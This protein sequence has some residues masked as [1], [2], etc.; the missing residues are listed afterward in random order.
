MSQQKIRLMN[1]KNQWMN[2]N[3]RRMVLVILLI[4]KYKLL[5]QKILLEKLLL[6]L[7]ILGYF[8]FCYA[9]DSSS[10]TII[11]LD[12]KTFRRVINEQFSNLITGQTK[13]S[14][15]NFASLDLKESE[16]SF[17]G[18]T[19]TKAG[20]VFGLVASG[21]VSDGLFSIFNN[22]TLN[23]KISLEAQMNFLNLSK[24]SL[25]W[26]DD[27]YQEYMK[28]Q[29]EIK[30]KHRVKL[31]EAENRFALINLN[32]KKAKLEKTLQQLNE[33][34]ATERSQLTSDS[35]NY[36]IALNQSELTETNKAITSF[37]DKVSA[38]E[39][40]NNWRAMEL[41]KIKPEL[42]L[43]GFNF[44]WWSLSYK[45]INNSFKLFDPSKE[46]QKQ[47]WDSSFVTHQVKLQYSYYNWT[48]ESN[49][50]Y[51]YCIGISFGVLDN[52]SD[53]TKRE[54]TEV[55]NYGANINDRSTTK[56]YNAYQGGYL[57]KL[58]QIKLF[59]DYYHFL[60]EGNTAAFHL[61]PEFQFKEGI[62]PLYNFGIGLLLAFK[63]SKKDDKS[64]VNAEIFYNF[65]DL[66]NNEDNN[67]GFLERN[68]IGLRFSFPINFVNK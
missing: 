40:V 41:K 16:V 49:K 4:S 20:H 59:G 27:S 1:Q 34:L 12:K 15:G 24:Q 25:T 14:I 23:T 8:N 9:Q 42:E 35:L 13:T 64:V 50:T 56:K 10:S 30:D 37:P 29:A 67:L 28:K 46:Y 44:G 58:S 61:Y 66:S 55:K 31:V 11:G 53:L 5:R 33:R 7:C 48:K 18:N 17:A 43:Y 47:V 65:L 62:K 19:I 57:S 32:Y 63:D 38:I 45:V 22:S 36:A 68:N 3:S 26:Y 51:F 39:D 60:F 6:V 54:I 2:Q 52:F 21:G